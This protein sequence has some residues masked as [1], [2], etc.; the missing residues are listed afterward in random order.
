MAMLQAWWICNKTSLSA[1]VNLPT[2]TNTM[3]R[4]APGAYTRVAYNHSSKQ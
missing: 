2:R 3:V 1:T 4:S